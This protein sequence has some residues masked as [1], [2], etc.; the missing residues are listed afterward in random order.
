M[1]TFTGITGNVQLDSNGDREPDYWVWD[2]KPSGDKFEV[3]I[4]ARMTSQTIEVSP[5]HKYLVIL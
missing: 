2:L 1:L 3:V 4:D 5:F